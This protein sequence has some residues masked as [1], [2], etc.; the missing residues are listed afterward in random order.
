MPNAPAANT[1][2]L[3]ILPQVEPFKEVFSPPDHWQ[4]SCS[5]FATSRLT[6]IRTVIRRVSGEA[7]SR[8]RRQ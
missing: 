6:Q 5:V 8:S 2:W 7:M 3:A 4:N 1:F